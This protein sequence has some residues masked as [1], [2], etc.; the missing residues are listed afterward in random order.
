MSYPFQITTIEQYH[1]DYKRSVE[2]PEGFWSD[3]AD[4]FEWKKNNRSAAVCWN[5]IL[6]NRK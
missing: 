6:Q 1:E 4:T 5:G 3:V 2:D